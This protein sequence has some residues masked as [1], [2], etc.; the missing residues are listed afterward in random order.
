VSTLIANDAS[1]DDADSSPPPVFIDVEDVTLRL[2]LSF[3][4]G[5]VGRVRQ[6]DFFTGSVVVADGPALRRRG[7]V[8]VLVV[9]PDPAGCRDGMQALVDGMTTGV[10][11]ADQPEDLPAALD[12]AAQGFSIVPRRVVDAA[13]RLPELDDRLA[14]TLG[15]VIAGR[16]NRAIAIALHESESTAKRD[17]GELL[18]RFDAPNRLVLAATAQALGFRRRT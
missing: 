9:S 17:I 4:L 12:A 18:R 6:R 7:R 2:A 1:T 16:S 3:V 5:D 15:L 8:D 14:R 11:L 10:L 13:G